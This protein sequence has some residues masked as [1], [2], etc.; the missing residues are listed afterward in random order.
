MPNL[1]RLR[2]APRSSSI[3]EQLRLDAAVHGPKEI[4]RGV[5]GFAYGQDAVVLEDGGFVLSK[6]GDYAAAFFVGEDYAAE[7]VV[8]GVVFVEA[9][10]VVVSRCI[11]NPR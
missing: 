6:G 3:S 7:I 4:R 8:E 2:P 11:I 10:K 1:H 5:Y 9:G